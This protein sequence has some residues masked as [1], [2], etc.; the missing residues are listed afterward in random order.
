MTCPCCG[1]RDFAMGPEGLLYCQSRDCA[2]IGAA[3]STTSSTRNEFG[4]E[5]Q[6]LGHTERVCCVRCGLRSSHN[7]LATIPYGA[8]LLPECEFTGWPPRGSPPEEFRYSSEVT[9]A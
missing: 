9:A 7:T 5:W 2:R 6:Y 1:G 8:V 3:F 4:H